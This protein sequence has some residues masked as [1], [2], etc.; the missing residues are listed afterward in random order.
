MELEQLL[1]KMYS[2]L[3]HP[4]LKN[5]PDERKEEFKRLYEQRILEQ[6]SQILDELTT[7]PI[8]KQEE[9]I[10]MLI[11]KEKMRWA[12]AT[13]E[14]K[15][16]YFYV[17]EEYVKLCDLSNEIFE[18]VIEQYHNETADLLG[19]R[20]DDI[21]RQANKLMEGID[22][23]NR[24]FARKA[25]S[26]LII[27]LNYLFKKS[28]QLSLR[29]QDYIESNP[30]GTSSIGVN[31]EK[32]ANREE[33]VKQYESNPNDLVQK[34]ELALAEQDYED[35]NDLL[36]AFFRITEFQYKDN[37]ENKY[38]RFN[39]PVEHLLYIQRFNPTA[40]IHNIDLDI[41]KAFLLKSYVLCDQRR[42]KEALSYLDSAFAWDPIYVNAYLKQ[43]KIYRELKDYDSWKE[44]LN[45]AYDFIYDA[46]S[47]QRYYRYL[48]YYYRTMGD[49]ETAKALHTL[50]YI[51]YPEEKNIVAIEEMA[52]EQG[53]SVSGMEFDEI[54]KI[55]NEKNI[56]IS[57][58]TKN[59]TI[60]E[61]IYENSKDNE[62][63]NKFAKSLLFGLT[64]DD[65]YAE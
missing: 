16:Q 13:F 2:E 52:E 3:L 4:F 41:N 60:L 14:N 9:T 51:Y 26:Y 64:K 28:D 57:A 43:A 1:E 29:F 62:E 49:Y 8:E 35:A 61:I 58:N 31:T 44:T 22:D 53:I 54:Q 56:P 65:K 30:T 15:Q 47:L 17:D 18:K 25:Y 46:Y 59:V 40:T 50:S 5:V 27:D 7:A 39:N 12:N 38:F 34:A 48:G 63:V 42:Y 6:Y 11:N 36:E 32:I 45:K 24:E 55:L 21:I 33:M 23:Y 20:Y 19:I 37:A 10:R